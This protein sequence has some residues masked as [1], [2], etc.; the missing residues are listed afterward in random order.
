[1]TSIGV[2]SYNSR[3]LLL[4]GK[5]CKLI[6]HQ[7]KASH[8]GEVVAVQLFDDQGAIQLLRLL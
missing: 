5:S 2:R 1:M 4:S 7:R 3:V 6:F 8:G